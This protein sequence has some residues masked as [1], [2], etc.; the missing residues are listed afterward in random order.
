MKKLFNRNR[1]ATQTNG[2][3]TL[4][5]KAQI[6]ILKNRLTDSDYKVIKCQ[7]CALAGKPL[8][9]DVEE[10]HRE[11]QAIRNKINELQGGVDI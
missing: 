1:Q 9:Y 7:E 8:P 10:L 3:D 6:E 2:L 11:R 4:M 5:A